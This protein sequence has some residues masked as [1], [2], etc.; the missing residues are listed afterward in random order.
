MIFDVTL[1]GTTHR[2]EVRD[3]NDRYVVTIDGRAREVDWQGIGSFASLVIDGKSHEVGVVSQ[4]GGYAVVLDD[5]QLFV[6][7]TE[8]ARS[9]G[10]PG[11]KAEGGPSKVSAPMP[12]KI[13]RVLAQPGQDVAAGQGLVVMEAMKMENELRAP[14]AGRVVDLRVREG[15]AVE[16]GALLVVME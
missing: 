10:A 16:T 9:A 5:V 14:R 4:T 3:K 8:G 12:G 1:N 13:V 11:A 15:Q 7:V 2:I 6:E